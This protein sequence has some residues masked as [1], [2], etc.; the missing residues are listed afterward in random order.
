MR[1][2]AL[3]ALLF[4]F[5]ANAAETKL[6]TIK[7]PNSGKGEAQAAFLRGVALLHNFWYVE[8]AR[9]FRE[10][11]KIDPDFAL[12]IWGEAMTANHPI[13]MEVSVDDG[14]AALAKLHAPPADERERMY[15]DAVQTLYGKGEKAT[16]DANYERAMEKLAHA[17]PDDVEAQVFW[18]LSIL[19]TMQRD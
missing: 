17:Y 6:G 1:H 10:A 14:R 12:A 11:E 7:F 16:R 13:W 18:A 5:S 3:A 8:A 9:A 15:I 19:G 4:A 2:F